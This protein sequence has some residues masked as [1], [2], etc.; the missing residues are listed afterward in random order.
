M[1]NGSRALAH[2]SAVLCDTQ[3]N[4]FNITLC[5]NYLLPFYILPFTCNNTSFSINTPEDGKRQYPK[6]AGSFSVLSMCNSF[7]YL[8]YSIFS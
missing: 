7:Y 1:H 8:F 6:Y 4:N 2:L 5:F 3:Y